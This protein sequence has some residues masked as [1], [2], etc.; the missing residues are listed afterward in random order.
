MDLKKKKRKTE[1]LRLVVNVLRN[2]FYGSVERAGIGRGV[3]D[4]EVIKKAKQGKAEK[5]RK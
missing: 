5:K 3:R 1:R 2:V 4:I